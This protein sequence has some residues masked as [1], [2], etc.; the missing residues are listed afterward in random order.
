MKKGILFII[1]FL[2]MAM[3]KSLALAVNFTDSGSYS[4]THIKN[5]AEGEEISST[6]LTKQQLAV[7]PNP[8][9]GDMLT[10]PNMKGASLRLLSL[11]GQELRSWSNIEEQ[12]VI[13][14]IASGVYLLE[15]LHKGQ[16]RITKIVIK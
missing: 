5:I 3:Q 13:Q 6:K 12:I 14:N 9:I 4:N 8:L 7:Y 1:V 16:R 15:V 11:L 10:V 2:I